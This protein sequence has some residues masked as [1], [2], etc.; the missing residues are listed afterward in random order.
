MRRWGIGWRKARRRCNGRCR[1]RGARGGHEGS[2]TRARVTTTLRWGGDINANRVRDSAERWIGEGALSVLTINRR[3]L[4]FNA[5]LPS[6]RRRT[7]VGR[8]LRIGWTYDRWIVVTGA[9]TVTST[10]P[11]TRPGRGSA[12]SS[13]FLRK[14]LKLTRRC[15]TGQR[16]GRL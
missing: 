12:N 7:V 8:T 10:V 15:P 9:V 13:R 1:R 4:G 5:R 3:Y 11:L 16:T 14:V 6:R 2:G